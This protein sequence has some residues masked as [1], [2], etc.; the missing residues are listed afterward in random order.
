MQLMTVMLLILPS[1]QQEFVESCDRVHWQWYPSSRREAKMLNLGTLPI[2]AAS[3]E[4]ARSPFVP[5]TS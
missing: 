5:Y 2:S 4:K 3:P 1:F